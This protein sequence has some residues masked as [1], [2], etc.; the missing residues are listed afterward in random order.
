[1][2]PFVGEWVLEAIAP[3]GE[4]WLGQE[5]PRS[6]GMRDSRPQRS[7]TSVLRSIDAAS[8]VGR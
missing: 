4:A 5:G 3:G 1:M 2:E 6:S 7:S 8:R